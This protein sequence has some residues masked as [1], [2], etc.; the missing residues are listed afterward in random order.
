MLNFFS[1]Q[2]MFLSY[3]VPLVAEDE[4]SFYAVWRI[5]SF[6]TA[7]PDGGEHSASGSGGLSECF[8]IRYIVLML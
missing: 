2:R 6:L 1:H 3:I 8:C 4:L 5:H 7:K